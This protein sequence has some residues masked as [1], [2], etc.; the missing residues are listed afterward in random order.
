MMMKKYLL[1]LALITGSMGFKA[2]AQIHVNI[3]IGAQPVWGPVGY[4]RADYYY[5]PDIDA[6]Y[7]VPQ[8]QFIYLE[9]PN[10]VFA[11]TLPY[12]YRNYDL[13]HG[14]KVVV[15]EPRPYL[16]HD[17]YRERYSRFRGN[18]GQQIIRDSRDERYRGNRN[19]GDGYRREN[20]EG[21]GRGRGEG[22]HDNGKHKGHHKD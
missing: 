12:R 19:D 7:D 4:D 6:Y 17:V 5:M 3:N 8:R 11:R 20:D 9:G 13:Y 22:H 16:H 21:N 2:T 1:I 18:R 14:Y 15:N 10:W